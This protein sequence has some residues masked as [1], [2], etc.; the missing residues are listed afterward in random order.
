VYTIYTNATQ[1]AIYR[2]S[3][4]M[5]ANPVFRGW[6]EAQHVNV[7]WL[8]PYVT[9]I[10]IGVNPY[11]YSQGN[12]TVNGTAYQIYAYLLPNGTAISF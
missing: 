10:K 4:K 11:D 12:V 9:M 2:N 5:L 8:A 3:S 6:L 1:N 7:S